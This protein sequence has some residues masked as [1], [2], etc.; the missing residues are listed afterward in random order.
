MICLA[1][2]FLFWV[3]RDF[4]F[5]YPIP[6]YFIFKP[7]LVDT[8]SFLK[9]KL[10]SKNSYFR[11]EKFNC[12][13]WQKNLPLSKIRQV[14]LKIQNIIFLGLKCN[15]LAKNEPFLLENSTT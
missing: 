4:I 9:I 11:F 12:F 1:I 10:F 6:F 2:S 14:G 5:L 8:S 3:L 15:D 7:F 13:F